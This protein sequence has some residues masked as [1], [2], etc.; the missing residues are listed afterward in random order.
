M[1]HRSVLDLFRS[2]VDRACCDFADH[3]K[4]KRFTLLPEG[5][6]VDNGLLTPTLKMRRAKIIDRYQDMINAMYDRPA[7]EDA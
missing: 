5:F 4:V 6:S 1:E 2:E 7:M 3:E